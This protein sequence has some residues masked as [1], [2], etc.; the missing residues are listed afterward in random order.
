MTER[1]R[2]TC[3]VKSFNT[4]NVLDDKIFDFFILKVHIACPWIYIMDLNIYIYICTNSMLLFKAHKW[5]VPSKSALIY[6]Q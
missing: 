4:C 1:V 2:G 3:T 6:P 5:R